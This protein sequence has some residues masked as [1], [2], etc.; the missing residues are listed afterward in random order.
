MNINFHYFTIKTLACAAGFSETE[1]QQIAKYSQF[2]DDYNPSPIMTCTNIP[3]KII[4]SDSLDLYVR[5]GVGNFRPVATGFTNAFE[6]AGLLLRRD[7]QLILSPFHFVPFDETQAGIPENRVVPLT[8]ND[9]SLVD[10]FLHKEILSFHDT[11]SPNISLMRIGMLLH[12]FADTHAHQFFTGFISQAN[13]VNIIKAK[14]NVT[15]KD[16]TS[17]VREDIRLIKSTMGNL[18]PIGHVQ[19]G[20]NPD[21]S[22]IVFTFS[23][24]QNTEDNHT[25]DNTAIFLNA[26]SHVYSYLKKCKKNAES[27]PWEDLALILRQ[28]LLIEIP[29]RNRNIVL[30]R[31][32]GQLF[33]NY[34]YE[35]NSNAIVRDFR[36]LPSSIG[37]FLQNAL[38]AYTDEFYEY[39]IMANEILV[40]LYGP[41]PR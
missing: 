25:R 22:D 14:S 35:Y 21:L 7:Q 40:A 9:N 17:K 19:A 20:H 8:F 28:G 29:R 12:I 6:Y 10:K 5:S 13:R 30:A 32:W 38:S 18:P 3:E 26:A 15:N 2:V 24:N 1:A 4:T 23:Y 27:I 36:E 31:H 33:P 41:R 37:R 11:K 34:K 39:N 16:C